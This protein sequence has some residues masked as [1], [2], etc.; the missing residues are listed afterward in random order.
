MRNNGGVETERVRGRGV[1]SENEKM[2]HKDEE[3]GR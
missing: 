3:R 1:E 2:G